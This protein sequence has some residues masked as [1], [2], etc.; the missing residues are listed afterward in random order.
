MFMIHNLPYHGITL[1]TFWVSSLL[2][3][4]MGD[5]IALFC[6]A[7]TK[8]FTSLEIQRTSFSKEY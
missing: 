1:W 5:K 6:L 7:Q 2:Y 4:I 3:I 8:A